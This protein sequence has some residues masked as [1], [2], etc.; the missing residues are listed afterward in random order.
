MTPGEIVPVEIEIWP[1]SMVYKKGHRLVVEV[2]SNDY[3]GVKPFF[4]TDPTDRSPAGTN[5]IHT[6]GDYDS[7]IL[8]PVI[9]AR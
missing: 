1:T 6:G 4:H 2:G 8:L 9:P 5:I 7:H 3:P